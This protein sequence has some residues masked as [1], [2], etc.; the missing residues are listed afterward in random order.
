MTSSDTT[1]N[2]TLAAR[3]REVARQAPRGSVER[4]SALCAVVAL[5]DS[6]SVATARKVLAGL[7]DAAIRQ[8]AID[9]IGELASGHHDHPTTTTE[10]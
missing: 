4:R 9:L 10:E 2:R 3:A 8:A 7:D 1:G 5:D 6:R